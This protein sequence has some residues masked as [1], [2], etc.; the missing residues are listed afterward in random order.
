MIM[1]EGVRKPQP[2]VEIRLLR[3]G[4]DWQSG[5]KLIE[6]ENLGCYDFLIETEADCG[7][8]DIWDNRSSPNGSF[9]GKTYTIGK[10]D[11]RGLLNDCIYYNNILDGVVNGSKIANETNCTE[12]LKNGLLSFTKVQYEIQ[13]QDKGEGDSS[14]ASNVKLIE[15]KI[16]TDVLDKEFQELRTSS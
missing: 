14:Q 6:T 3:P 2:G 10:L 1:E 16:I 5:T 9:S 7:I 15:D 12:R 11:A 8:Y 13:D 4:D